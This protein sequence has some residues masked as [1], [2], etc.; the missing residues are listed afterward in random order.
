M[1][2]TIVAFIIIMALIIAAIFLIVD[3]ACLPGRIAQS[4][5]HPHA[6]AVKIAGVI[7]IVT[8]VLWFLALIWAYV[9]YPSSTGTR[10]ASGSGVSVPADG[11]AVRETS[12]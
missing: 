7:G 10:S 8:G 4:R 2:L 11:T 12:V 3:L 5:G 9:P 1:I 6:D